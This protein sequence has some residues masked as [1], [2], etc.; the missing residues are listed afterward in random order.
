[1]KIALSDQAR[2]DIAWWNRTNPRMTA[3]V[4]RLLEQIMENPFSGPGRPEPLKYE[5]SGWWSRRISL[6]HRLVYRVE[7][8]TI[9]VLSCRYHYR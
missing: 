1:M 7:G 6:E 4:R 8:D 3:R 5:L 2:E 9:Q